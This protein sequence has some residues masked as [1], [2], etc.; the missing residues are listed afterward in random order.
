MA[1]PGAISMLSPDAVGDQDNAEDGQKLT[2]F[3]LL[4]LPAELQLR[5]IEFAVTEQAPIWMTY[6]AWLLGKKGIDGAYD[7]EHEGEWRS[8]VATRKQPSITRVSRTIRVDAIKMYYENNFFEA[9]YCLADVDTHEGE[10]TIEWLAAIGLENRRRI[11][12]LVVFDTG[13]SL[14]EIVE[15]EYDTCLSDFTEKMD[16]L[17]FNAVIGEPLKDHELPHYKVR[18]F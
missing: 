16:V 14:D 11:R 15:E 1:E 7:S 12:D 3:R 9:G 6:G 17:G 13:A 4:D 8:E 2:T 5:I 18:E 10:V